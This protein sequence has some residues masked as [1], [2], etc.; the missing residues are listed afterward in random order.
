M[1]RFALVPSV[2]AIVILLGVS[3]I[4]F[5]ATSNTQQI[6]T[7]LTASGAVVH[8][9]EVQRQLDDVLLTIAEAETGQQA[10]LMTGDETRLAA[11]A[12]AE[13]HLMNQF[14]QL[15]ALASDN[16]DQVA[17]VERLHE[18][19]D[20]Q[21]AAMATAIEEARS[22]RRAG[23][24]TAPMLAESRRYVNELRSV[25]AEMAAAE[26]TLLA[27]RQAQAQAA[28]EAAVA[29]RIGSSIA[30]GL[31][32]V[33]LAVFA[34]A[35]VRARERTART[36][37][38]ERERQ[39]REDAR[40]EEAARAE[41]EKANRSKDEFLAVLSHELRTPLNAVLG[42]AQILQEKPP[43]DPTLAKGLASIKRNAE[44]QKRLV[45]DLLD[46]SRIVA[47]K[48]SIERKPIDV[49][50]PVGAALDAIRPA[51]EAKGVELQ[52]QLNGAVVVHADPDRIAQVASNLLSNAVKFTPKGG[53][54]DATLAAANGAVI[55][56]VKDTGEG[57]ARD[58]V[59][60]IFDRFRQGDGTT[61]RAHGGLGL[62]LAIVKHIVDAHGGTIE[63]LS[64]GEG[65]GATFLVRLPV[66]SNVRDSS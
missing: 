3:L 28:Y 31:L 50:T 27:E 29:G 34:A 40:R 66:A 5:F 45:E 48:F 63:A 16:P 18:T 42:W 25:I 23:R 32:F 10:F 8:T 13:P 11:Y 14:R 62:G 57:L 15:R 49:R 22:S 2:L 38:E 33:S 60:H 9:L 21:L 1:R 61:T 6:Q 53:R 26:A 43:Q 51:A 47:G 58:L 12:S 46:V 19:T 41:A 7:L 39:Y 37:A 52:A 65:R 20:R 56:S 55:L 64:E 35:W 30:S 36:L 54:V 44:A 4:V 17:R 24:S 59:P